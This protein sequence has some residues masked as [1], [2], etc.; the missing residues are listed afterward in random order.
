MRV[1]ARRV[2]FTTNAAGGGTVVTSPILGRV[3]ELRCA[4]AGTAWT[5]TGG[6]CDVT[7]TRSAADDGGTIV[8]AMNVTAPF[9]ITPVPAVHL[10]SNGTL[11]GTATGAPMGIPVADE[12]TVVIAQAQP[13]QAGTIVIHTVE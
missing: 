3:L 7:L 10:V 11:A 9:Q 13:S 8:A 4:N 2:A 1:R 12:V 5:G 6:T